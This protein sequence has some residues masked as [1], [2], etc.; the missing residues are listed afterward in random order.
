MTQNANKEKI[1]FSKKN[2]KIIN[3]KFGI[4]INYDTEL[5]DREV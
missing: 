5:A 4:R 1:F 2:K 3:K